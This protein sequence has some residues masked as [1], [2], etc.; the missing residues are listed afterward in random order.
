MTH[1]EELLAGYVDGAL[2]DDE[3]AV[4]DAHLDSCAACRDEVELA[5]SAVAALASLPDVPVPFGVTGPV[6]AE[7]GRR[8]E[9]RRAVV[10]QRVQW[11]AGLAAAAAL[12]LVVAIN[13]GGADDGRDGTV[14]VEDDAGGGEATGG[15]S[16]E[17]AAAI[18]LE[19]QVG[20]NYDDEGVRSLAT[21]TAAAFRS[22][23]ASPLA[24]ADQAFED[25]NRALRCLRTSGAPLD[26]P[27]DTLL[28]LIEAEYRETPAY[29]ALFEES[30]GA[31][32]PPTTV[33]VWAASVDGCTLI[34]FAS[35]PL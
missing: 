30:P 3:R 32:Q 34:T 1:P 2:A 12:V 21:D 29:F 9:R 24:G 17:M 20:V 10:W 19:S 33:L 31:G 5:R 6:L 15:A 18:Q 35:Q 14:A 23:E 16:A 28:R 8:F 25:P 27:R 22:E 11:A 26:D 4:V 7:A 13:L